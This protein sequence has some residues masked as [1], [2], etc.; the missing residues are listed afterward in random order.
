MV[1]S[2]CQYIGSI[3]PIGIVTGNLYTFNIDNPF[4][5]ALEQVGNSLSDRYCINQH[6]VGLTLHNSR[7]CAW[8]NCIVYG[9]HQG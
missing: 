6:A 4:L 1:L 5:L 2:P 3:A 8:I 9:G 7:T